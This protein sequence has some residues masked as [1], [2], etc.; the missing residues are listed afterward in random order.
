MV[1]KV[2]GG[3]LFRLRYRTAPGRAQ[4]RLDGDLFVHPE[5]AM[6][7]IEEALEQCAALPDQEV[8][9]RFLEGKLQEGSIMIIGAG[10]EDLISALWEAKA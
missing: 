10:A 8:A 9:V 5:E 2:P 7:A 1:R 3:K 6:G 4:V